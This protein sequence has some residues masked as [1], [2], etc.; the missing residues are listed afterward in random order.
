[1]PGRVGLVAFAIEAILK[2]WRSQTASDRLQPETRR[3]A[4]PFFFPFPRHTA[5]A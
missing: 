3:G 2:K 1:M 4:F 5:F